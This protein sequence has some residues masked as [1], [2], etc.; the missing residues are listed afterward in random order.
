MRPISFQIEKAIPGSLARAGI[1]RTAHGD[2]QTPAFIAVATKATVKGVSSQRFGELGVQ[3]VIANT[4][5]L[6]LTPGEKTVEKAGGVHKFMHWEGPVMTDSGGFQVFSL[7]V[8]FG[9]KISK[10]LPSDAESGSLPA[11]HNGDGR[12]PDS[13][14][15]AVFDEELATSHGKLAIIDEDGVSF[16]LASRRLVPPLYA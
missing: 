4:Y 9:K 2:I 8:G 7:G 16:T 5:H 12:E 3:G 13:A 14:S 6:Y 11:G 15:P 1:L 10:F